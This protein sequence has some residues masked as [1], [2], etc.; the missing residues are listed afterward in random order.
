MI[1]QLSALLTA[2]SVG[3]S[4]FKTASMGAQAKQ[5]EAESRRE[6]G[7]GFLSS[8]LPFASSFLGGLGGPAAV[9]PIV[10]SLVESFSG[11]E[12]SRIEDPFRARKVDMLC[13]R[14]I[15]SDQGDRDWC[16]GSQPPCGIVWGVADAA[17]APP[18]F[19]VAP[20]SRVNPQTGRPWELCR[21]RT[22]QSGGQI[23]V[24]LR[25]VATRNA[26]PYQRDAGIP[27]PCSC[28]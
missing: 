9:A 17:P 19:V 26:D 7:G 2:A 11:S 23:A 25:R 27:A 28:R 22:L 6:S 24:P 20:R 1:M 3:S 18:G 12:R 5:Q 15:I 13:D 8:F 4:F 16:G 21:S 14:V 10:G